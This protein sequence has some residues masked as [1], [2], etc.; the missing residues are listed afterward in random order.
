MSSLI[1]VFESYCSFGSSKTL[2]MNSMGGQMDGAKFAKLCKDKK[3][4]SGKITSTDI[5]IIFNKVKEKTARK[6]GFPEFMEALKLIAAKKYEDK[7]Q[8]DALG[9]LINDMLTNTSSLPSLNKTT[10]ASTSDLT[11]RLT[12]TSQ[13]TGTHKQRFDESGQGRGKAGRDDG[14]QI[15]LQSIANRDDRA[16][17]RGVNQSFK[18]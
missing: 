13:Y 1:E 11:K 4:I 6:I 18:K 10:K 12:D 16:D 2:S 8:N 17:V 3:L 15:T 14:S 9:T 5:D 7:S